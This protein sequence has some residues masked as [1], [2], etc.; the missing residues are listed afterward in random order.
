MIVIKLLNKIICINFYLVHV[1][2][3]FHNNI[4]IL[5]FDIHIKNYTNYKK[6]HG[7]FYDS[8][9]EKIT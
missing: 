1:S 7:T 5:S 4:L 8:I 3:Y 6:L 2:N 9:Q